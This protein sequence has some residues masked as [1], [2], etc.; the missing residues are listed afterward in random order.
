MPNTRISHSEKWSE[1]PLFTARQWVVTEDDIAAWNDLTYMRTLVD[2]IEALCWA[3]NATPECGP[4][5]EFDVDI[6]LAPWPDDQAAE[7]LATWRAERDAVA[8]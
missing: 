8:A 6:Y 5:A 3:T 1:L 2:D 4:S 7:A